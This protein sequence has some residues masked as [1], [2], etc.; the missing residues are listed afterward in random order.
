VIGVGHVIAIARDSEH[1]FSKQITTEI[2]IVAGLG[3]EEMLTKGAR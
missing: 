3:V 1:R 2:K